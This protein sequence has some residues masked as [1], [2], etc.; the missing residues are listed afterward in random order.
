MSRDIITEIKK[1]GLI[2]RSGADFPTGTKLEL[3]KKA[4][5]DKKYVVCNGSEG[6]PGVRK[7]FY[8]LK[9]YPDE[10][11][12]GIKIAIT[13]LNAEKGFIY[14]N[15]KYYNK[16]KKKLKEL[17]GDSPIEVFKKPE[18]A[19]YVGGVE[20]TAMNV[21]EGKRAEPRLRPPFPI[22]CGLWNYPTLV[23]NIETFYD[24]SLISEGKYNNKRFYTINRNFFHKGVYEFPENFTIEKILTETE[25]YPK[26]DFFVQ[27][28]GDA[29]GEVLN[30]NQLNRP[31]SGAG[32]IT[33]YNLSKH[34]PLKLMKN[35]I[36]FFVEESCG[37]C[38]PCREGMYRL[39][40]IIYSSN[41][42]WDL[43]F[44]IMNNLNETSFCGLGKSLPIP[45]MT[46]FNNILIGLPENQVSSIKNYQ[47]LIHN[48]KDPL[49][50]R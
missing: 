42:N 11:I 40:E 15:P 6:E 43:F 47:S 24:I 19:G 27:V 14:L 45:I 9:N 50:K 20:T 46:Y 26:F 28:G 12:K 16:F 34:N 17:I 36:D 8:I 10:L 1:S 30:R 35:W 32:S 4:T 33:I 5:G 22:T 37:Q 31:V 39:R 29:S 13:T 2:G 44:E 41:P 38:V 25:N 18:E 3:V 7:D 48:L 21:I 23:N 49:N